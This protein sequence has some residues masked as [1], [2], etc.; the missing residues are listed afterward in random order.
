M[1]E[2]PFKP[3]LLDL[4]RQARIAQDAFVQAL[5]TTERAA[6]GS[7]DH[8]SAKDHVAH[9]TFWRQ[10]LVLKLQAIQRRET[11]ADSGDFEHLNPIIFE[12]QRQRPWSEVLTESDQAYAELLSLTDQLTDDDLTAFNRFD[13]LPDGWP[14]YTAFMGF[15][16]EHAQ[17]HFAQYY[18]DRD[19]D[20][21]PRARRCYEV[22]AERV[23]QAEVPEPLKGYVLYNLACFYATHAE[24]EQASTT[25]RQACTLYPSL[26]ELARTDP[27]L[28]ALRSNQPET[29]S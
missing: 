6:T 14:L 22:W 7:P 16:Y 5:D 27:D 15:C 11:P 9:M 25:F 17:Q 3:I 29:L 28:V 2:P 18:L 21:F 23:V 1:S 10:R 24:L 13:W 4:L 20:D 19:R 26:K 8:W 12:Q